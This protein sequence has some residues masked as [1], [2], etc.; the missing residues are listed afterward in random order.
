TSSTCKPRSSGENYLLEPPEFIDSE[1]STTSDAILNF[2]LSDIEIGVLNKTTDEKSTSNLQF[3]SE[4]IQGT[5]S[6]EISL[7]N[8]NVKSESSNMLLFSENF[9]SP[10]ACN[11]LYD[12]LTEKR[13][14][15]LDAS[16][17]LELYP[18]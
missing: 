18:E 17:D 16:S 6:N 3:N 13:R 11:D 12:S 4:F 10:Q 8:L 5:T 2:Q 7:D 9:S 15:S 14:L 1:S